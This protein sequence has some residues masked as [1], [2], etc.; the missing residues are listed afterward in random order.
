MY[1]CQN[2]HPVYAF[3]I[4]LKRHKRKR[5]L[6]SSFFFNLDVSRMGL[7]SFNQ[8][9]RLEALGSL[10]PLYPYTS[11]LTRFVLICYYILQRSPLFFLK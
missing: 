5:F 8:A 6:F 11:E 9:G 4:E 3:D 1:G 2:V 10:E 7:L